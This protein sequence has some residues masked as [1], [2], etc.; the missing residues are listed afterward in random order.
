MAVSFR[1]LF[2][3]LLPHWLLAGDGEK[4][5]WSHSVVFDGMMERL[6]QGIRARFPADAPED[7]L[8]RIGRDRRITRGFDESSD[9][10]RLRLPGYLTDWGQAGA[11]WPMLRQLVGYCG[12]A[13]IS[14]TVDN[15][16]NWH[17]RSADGA[18]TS[19]LDQGNWDW[20]GDTSKWA[21][22][23]PILYP[24]AELWTAGPTLG[25]PALWG[26]ALGTPG[27]TVGSTA[28]PEQ[29]A[30]VKNLVREWKPAGSRCPKVV[31]A[32]DAD[33]FEPTD[34]SPPNPDGDW[35]E[36]DNRLPDAAF[37]D[38]NT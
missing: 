2:R 32:F 20:D 17:T 10:Y 14:R 24:P 38:P 6:R 25:D 16:G 19:L 34:A 9:N 30:A 11:P 21:R 22:F 27:Y 8:A 36:P 31:I 35:S 12:V 7:A 1:S 18:E 37:W 29:V 13:M 26:G 23:W 5:H 4:V 28:T 15:R 3:K 33:D